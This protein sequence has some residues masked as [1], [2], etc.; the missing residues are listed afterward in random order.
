MTRAVA[1]YTG[2]MDKLQRDRVGT[3]M[4]THSDPKRSM[5]GGKI[6]LKMVAE[7]LV[8]HG[9]D[10]TEE[11]VKILRPTDPVTGKRTNAEGKL[12]PSLLP[13]EVQARIL[14]DLLQYCQPKLKSVEIS[15]SVGIER[16]DIT[17]EQARRI[18]AEFLKKAG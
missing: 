4:K 11:I 17:D 1:K 7:V 18:A 8:A 3:A 13:A 16:L 6:N 5:V 9:M 10:P 15:G 2:S 14:G 12:I